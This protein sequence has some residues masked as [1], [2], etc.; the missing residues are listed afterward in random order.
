MHLLKGVKISSIKSRASQNNVSSLLTL[1]HHHQ[2][3]SSLNDNMSQ[4]N[5]VDYTIVTSSSY[6]RRYVVNTCRPRKNSNLDQCPEHPHFLSRT[7]FGALAREQAKKLQADRDEPLRREERE[8]DK[9]T[10]EEQAKIIF[11]RMGPIRNIKIENLHMRPGYKPIPG[12]RH[13]RGY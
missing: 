5:Q 3:L 2:Q 12:P 1:I 11:H 13:I 10:L 9:F 8:W 6:H 4:I 7:S